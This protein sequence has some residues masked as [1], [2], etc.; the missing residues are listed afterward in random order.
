M[1]IT[2]AVGTNS[3]S[4]PELML[5]PQ[6]NIVGVMQL[7]VAKLTPG[8]EHDGRFDL[9]TVIEDLLKGKAQLWVVATKR[10]GI[11]LC[12][13]TEI[14][15][16]PKLKALGLLWSGGRNWNKYRDY[17][18]AIEQ[19]GVRQGCTMAEMTGRK[20]F[21]PYMKSRGYEEY[22]YMRKKLAPEVLH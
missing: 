14:R 13:V 8:I 9:L 15:E 22:A 21:I 19:W 11:E 4:V 16:Y 17:L 3:D 6:Q 10:H 2:A 12:M 1:D 18:S 7:C 20:G 5:I